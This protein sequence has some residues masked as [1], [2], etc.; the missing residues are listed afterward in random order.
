MERK[1]FEDNELIHAVIECNFKKVKELVENK[2]SAP[3]YDIGGWE[4]QC[5]VFIISK[6]YQIIFEYICENKTF[7]KFF[8]IFSCF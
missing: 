6:A 5:K 4:K 1:F 7:V 2:F 3:I 8:C